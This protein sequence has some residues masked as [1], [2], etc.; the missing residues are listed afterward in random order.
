MV[1]PQHDLMAHGQ[2]CALPGRL[3]G[4]TFDHPSLPERSVVRR[5]QVLA[6]SVLAFHNNMLYYA[7]A[8][9]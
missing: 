6:L 2:H 1:S 4:V 9:R 7:A 8:S 5:S 3:T